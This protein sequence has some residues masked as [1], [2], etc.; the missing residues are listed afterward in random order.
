MS[1]CAYIRNGKIYIPSDAIT[2]DGIL[3][4]I[5]PIEVAGIDDEGALKSAVMAAILRG[6]RRIPAPSREDW[7][8]DPVLKLAGV[9]TWSSFYKGTRQLCFMR[10]ES[11]FEIVRLKPYERGFQTDETTRIILPADLPLERAVERIVEE[12]QREGGA[13][14]DPTA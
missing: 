10:R 2:P 9:R 1:W 6:R 8:N 3:V 5:E 12:I 14:A 4:G 7:K 11:G 13:V